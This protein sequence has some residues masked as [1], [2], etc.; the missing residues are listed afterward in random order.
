[1]ICGMT[2]YQVAWFF[3]IYSLLGWII[4]VAYHAVTLGKVINR[5]FLNGPICP[6]YG[7]GV[8]LVLIVLDITGK[9]F[10]IETSVDKA[11]SFLLF[12][13]GILFATAIELL[14]GFMLDKLFHARWWDYSDRKFNLNGYICLEFSII[15]GL[16][17]AFVLRVVHPTFE[18]CVEFIPKSFG[19]ILL[20]VIYSGYLADNII[21][22]LTV[23]KLNKELE[24]MEEIRKSILIVSDGMSEI[25]GNSTIKMV[26]KFEKTHE[27]VSQKKE[28][29]SERYEQLKKEELT[30]LY[31]RLKKELT[32]YKFFG[33]SRLLRAFPR[34][35]HHLYQEII[36]M[37]KNGKM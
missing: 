19:V 17:I 2:I 36:D 27:E 23:L 24:M 22:V 4:E 16:A 26:D 10:G 25:I 5:G 3:M 31:D 13:I 21:T 29:L 34:M 12:I 14:A 11:S 35:K 1:M 20:V 37:L 33:T 28:E 8:I 30:D 15:W 9:L 7:W 18:K 6:V 32:K